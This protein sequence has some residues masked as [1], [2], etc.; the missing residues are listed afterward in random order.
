MNPL[1]LQEFNSLGKD[2]WNINGFHNIEIWNEVFDRTDNRPAKVARVFWEE[3]DIYKKPV[4]K[5]RWKGD[6]RY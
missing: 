2:L 5:L 4:P 6:A 3:S 1:I